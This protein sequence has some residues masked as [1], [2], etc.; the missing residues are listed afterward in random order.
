[1]QTSLIVYETSGLI[2]SSE[3]ALCSGP[4]RACLEDEYPKAVGSTG[5]RPAWMHKDL[6]VLGSVGGRHCWPKQH[7]TFLIA[8]AYLRYQF[9]P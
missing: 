6:G 5:Q 7:Y 3:R 4:A 8:E 1:M 2:C 9:V